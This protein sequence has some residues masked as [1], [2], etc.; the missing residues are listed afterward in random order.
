[1]IEPNVVGRDF[2]IGLGDLDIAFG[3]VHFGFI[4]ITQFVGNNVPGYVR[5]IQGSCSDLLPM[6]RMT[7]GQGGA[8]SKRPA[9][10]TG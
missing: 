5:V 6:P 2:F 1:M 3:N 9:C 8:Q 4:V 7:A 10:T